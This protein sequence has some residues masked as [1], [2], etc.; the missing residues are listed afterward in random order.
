MDENQEQKPQLR[1]K[2]AGIDWSNSFERN[3]IFYS[4]EISFSNANALLCL[5]S[6]VEEMLNFQEPKLWVTIEPRWHSFWNKGIGKK[7]SRNLKLDEI[8]YYRHPNP[9]YR[10]PHLTSYSNVDPFKKIR[11]TDFPQE[12]AVAVVSNY[13]GRIHFLKKHIQIRNKLILSP[14]VN[15]YGSRN[16]WNQYRHF[17][18][19]WKVSPPSNY[20]GEVSGNFD[21]LI[22]FLSQ[23]KVNVCLENSFEPYYFTEKFVN[24]IRAGCIPVYHAHST[25]KET[26]L[27]GAIW[28]D[29]S[30]FNF[31]PRATIKFA[32]EQ[33]IHHYRRINDEWLDS[34]ILSTTTIHSFYEKICQIMERK[35]LSY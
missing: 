7:L 8:A 6:P 28:V 34:D 16:S 25:V 2:I 32:L 30:D 19:L 31:E 29:P 20:C 23:Y 24:S 3:G 4:T 35:L 12:K 18:F 22:G 17:P 9:E 11:V 13:G 27:K 26:F 5:Y 15:L 10:V 21:D 33:D 1:V 14:L